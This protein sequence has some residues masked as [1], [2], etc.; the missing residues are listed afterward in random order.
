MPLKC[1]C[2]HIH[3]HAHKRTHKC[4]HNSRRFSLPEVLSRTLDSRA[5][6]Q[7]GPTS[8]QYVVWSP[9]RTELHPFLGR[10]CSQ[11]GWSCNKH[12]CD[13]ATPHFQNSS[14]ALAHDPSQPPGEISRGNAGQQPLR[15]L[16]EKCRQNT[17]TL[18]LS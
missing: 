8:L 1:A 9:F 6:I 18:S 16:L 4:M 2:V 11:N 3:I 13:R 14:P 15:E 10:V 5:K 12:V 7:R 17:G